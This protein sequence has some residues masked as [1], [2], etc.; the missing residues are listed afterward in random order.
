M[1][2]QSKSGRNL[3]RE[4]VVG[5]KDAAVIEIKPGRDQKASTGERLKTLNTGW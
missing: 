4:L 5:Q 1:I 3:T 2:R